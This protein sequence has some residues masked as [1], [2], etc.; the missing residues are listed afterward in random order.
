MQLILK[1]N[2]FTTLKPQKLNLS[3]YSE[4]KVQYSLSFDRKHLAV[5]GSHALSMFTFACLDY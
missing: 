2:D 4:T 5:Y 1:N 3:I